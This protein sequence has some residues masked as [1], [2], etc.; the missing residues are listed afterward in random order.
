MQTATQPMP[1]RA[2]FCHTIGVMSTSKLQEL[3]KFCVVLE[4]KLTV[5]CMLPKSLFPAFSGPSLAGL[6][7]W[8]NLLLQK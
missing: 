8:L 2:G 1:S 4:H 6:A 3:Q 5:M 7:M